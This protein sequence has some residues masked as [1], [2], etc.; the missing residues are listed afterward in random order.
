MFAK[1]L[2]FKKKL[3]TTW[4]WTCDN[5]NAN[6]LLYRLS[7]MAAVFDGMLLE[8]SPLLRLQ[9]AAECNLIT[10]FT[11]G[12]KLEVGRWWVY[13]VRQLISCCRLTQ[14]SYRCDRQT[15]GRIFS[16]IYI[17]L[18]SQIEVRHQQ[19]SNCISSW[20]CWG[21]IACEIRLMKFVAF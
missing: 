17:D 5:L 7:H 1:V 21:V 19:V 9:P 2:I 4:I 6:Q 18:L 12:D 14:V 15:D 13:D 10:A 8:F 20:P 16:F 3:F 11:H